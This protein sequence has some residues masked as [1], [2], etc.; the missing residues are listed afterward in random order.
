MAKGDPPK[1]LTILGMG[2]VA[3]RLL[4]VVPEGSDG[5]MQA[6]V[7]LHSIMLIEVAGR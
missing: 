3:S 1:A 2:V 6:D 4:P 5:Q 7:K